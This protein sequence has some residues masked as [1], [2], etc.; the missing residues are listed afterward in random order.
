MCILVVTMYDNYVK[1]PSSSDEWETQFSGF[2]EN[3]EVLYVVP[4]DGLYVYVSSKIKSYFSFKKRYTMLSLGL[5]GYNLYAAVGAPGSTH[6][7]RILKSTRLYQS[8]LKGEISLEKAI[9]FEGSSNIS[10]VTIG[11][12]AFPKHPWLLKG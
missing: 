2:I 9:T 7:T 12:S 11:D 3:Y 5:V 6:D 4:W 1:L 8:I 10:L